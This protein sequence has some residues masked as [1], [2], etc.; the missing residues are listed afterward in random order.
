MT[1]NRGE[2][3]MRTI[4]KQVA[5]AAIALM[6]GLSSAFAQQ[7]SPI[8][9]KLVVPDTQVL[10]GVPFD[11]W[12]ELRNASDA[13][14][15]VGLFPRLLVRNDRG[16]SFEIASNPDDYPVLLRRSRHDGEGPL[17][18]VTLKR[19][20]KATLTLPVAD[21]L[22]GAQFFRDHRLS[23]PGR[24]TLAVRLETFPLRFETHDPAL[25]DRGAVTTTAVVVERI[26]PAG[27]DAKVW[28]RMQEVANGRWTAP[29]TT[30]TDAGPQY[31]SMIAR[32]KVWSEIL[33][34]YPDSNYVPYAILAQRSTD[35]S[36]VLD[37]VNR[38][39]QSPVAE[40]LQFELW[41]L[42]APS[43]GL[44]GAKHQ[45]ACDGAWAKVKQSGRP[46][47]RIRV[48]GREDTGKEPCPPDYDCAN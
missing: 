26:E 5:F 48:F 35:A 30:I 25:T 37:A 7:A 34:K 14:V 10:P 22:R 41:R 18:E 20:E 1:R 4:G 40:S 27:S 28:Q 42:T 15:T 46:T 16:E 44:P 6:L 8:E 24:Y 23:P 21:G 11:M 12:I 33:A 45:A 3:A 2:M 13:E 47:T 29:Q 39:P 19:N 9:A 31:E 32:G 36:A 43:C 17:T 38:F